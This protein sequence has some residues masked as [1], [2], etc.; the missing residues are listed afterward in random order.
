MVMDGLVLYINLVLKFC[1][2]KLSNK[3]D[4]L[5]IEESP[6][7]R[8]W[9]IFYIPIFSATVHTSCKRYNTALVKENQNKLGLSL[10]RLAHLKMALHQLW[11]PTKL[12]MLGSQC[13]VVILKCFIQFQL[14][15]QLILVSSSK[16]GVSQKFI[17]GFSKYW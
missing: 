9:S 4:I 5:F 1:P 10:P 6:R 15:L 3:V 16:V 14:T 17:A 2:A 7:I 11:L 12:L 8:V 13:D